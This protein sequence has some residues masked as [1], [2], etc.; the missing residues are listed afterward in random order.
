MPPGL[1][2]SV[3]VS[4]SR[5]FH[6]KDSQSSAQVSS[7]SLSLHGARS[8]IA[9]RGRWTGSDSHSASLN[10]SPSLTGNSIYGGYHREYSFQMRN[11]KE[12]LK[13]VEA[14]D[15]IHLSWKWKAGI[16]DREKKIAKKGLFWHF[17]F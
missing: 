15:L 5:A 13:I 10:I 6:Y 8:S 11:K 9:K 7:S 2:S 3:P 4:S 17:T 12:R 16:G 14:M 1:T